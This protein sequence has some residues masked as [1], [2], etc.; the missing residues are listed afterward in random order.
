MS[1]YLF[2]GSHCDDLELCAGG[3]ITKLINQGYD[4]MIVT[5]SHIY[6][7]QDLLSEWMDSMM[8]LRPASIQYKNFH[9]RTPDRQEILDYLCTLKADYVITHSSKDIHQA[10]K[11]VGEEAERAFKFTN[12]LTFTGEWNQRTNTKNYFVTLTKEDV[13]R[14]L[15]ALSCY[16][17]QSHRPYMNPD[18]IWANAMNT[19]VM[20]GVKYAEAFQVVNLIN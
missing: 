4:V 11:I 8:V 2:V 20:A 19:G 9:P 14:K 12:L 15:S 18:F 5:L 13:E 7:G 17:S 1:K 10:H 3:T 16:K 6:N